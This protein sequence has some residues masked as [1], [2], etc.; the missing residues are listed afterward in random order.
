MRVLFLFISFSCFG[1]HIACDYYF[2]SNEEKY[3]EE[4][5]KVEIEDEDLFLRKNKLSFLSRETLKEISSSEE[6]KYIVYLLQNT[7]L[8]KNITRDFFDYLNMKQAVYLLE[9]FHYGKKVSLW[10]KLFPSLDIHPHNFLKVLKLMNSNEKA[11]KGF[12]TLLGR[13][14]SVKKFEKTIN[15]VLALNYDKGPSFSVNVLQT[16]NDQSLSRKFLED[17]IASEL[18]KSIIL[19]YKFNQLKSFFKSLFNGKFYEKKTQRNIFTDFSVENLL[20]VYSLR[21]NDTDRVVELLEELRSTF[22][23]AYIDHSLKFVTSNRIVE[24]LEVLKEVSKLESGYFSKEIL[25]LVKQIEWPKLRLEYFHNNRR[26]T[27]KDSS[28]VLFRIFDNMLKFSFD[29]KKSGVD[30]VNEVK[31]MFLKFEDN[32]DKI[33]ITQLFREVGSKSDKT[34]DKFRGAHFTYSYFENFSNTYRGLKNVFNSKR[35]IGFEVP[36]L[37]VKNSRKQHDFLMKTI[38]GNQIMWFRFSDQKYFPEHEIQISRNKVKL[39]TRSYQLLQLRKADFVYRNNKK[40]FIKEMKNYSKDVGGV[41]NLEG[42]LFF[43]FLLH[44]KFKNLVEI[45][46]VFNQSAYNAPS[47]IKD[48]NDL[49]EKYLSLLKRNEFK[50]DDRDEIAEYFSSY[51]KG[52][53]FFSP[54]IDTYLD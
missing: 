29:P 7:N 11:W 44:Y 19:K 42:E 28:L 5:K 45:N 10:N 16:I 30:I 53:E 25:S 22:S 49:K 15:F 52:I 31:N 1:Y 38:K 2:K 33:G 39:A 40:F 26:N 34:N 4:P 12:K 54:R 27:S 14:F 17:V 18:E 20:K 51:E 24:S 46:W 37:L 32:H 21:S 35:V 48:Q 8:K 23:I 13:N 50:S 47:A 41:T 6:S 9:Y 43:D 36:I 3:F